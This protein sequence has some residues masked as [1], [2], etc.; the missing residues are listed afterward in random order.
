MI[1]PRA[2]AVLKASGQGWGSMPLF[3]EDRRRAALNN[4]VHARPFASVT[5]PM[6]ASH[7]AVLWGEGGAAADL[8]HLEALCRRHDVPPPLP[9]A[10][11]FAAGF[12]AFALK[13]ERH[14]EFST[15]IFMLEGAAGPNGGNAFDDPAIARVPQ[16]WLA[17]M[18][19]SVLVAAH[20][21]MQ[22]AES[23]MPDADSLARVLVA[24][25]TAGSGISG[26]VAHAWT[27]FQLHADGFG[28]VLVRDCG[29]DGRRMGPRQAGRMMQRL[30]EI[31]TYRM[32]ALLSLP[33]ARDHA[34][35]IDAIGE[36]LA[37]LTQGLS[38]I[39]G[40]DDERRLLDRLVALAAEAERIAAAT[41]Y[42]FGAGRA[43]HQLVLR[44]IE[45]LR[46]QRI[47]G[48]QTIGEFMDRRLAPAMRTCAS[49]GERLETISVR[50][51]RTTALLRARV[52]VALEA[53]NRD[54]LAS[55][56][57]RA[58]LQL[59][60]QQTVEGLSVAAICYYVVGL[61]AYAAKG[62]KTA[63]LPVEPD[64]ASALAVVPVAA[65]VWLALRRLRRRMT[66]D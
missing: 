29:A 17:A 8:A 41:T 43:Y 60:L 28:R 11:H 32:M 18:P 66:R 44:R 35:R 57:R 46:E 56:D 3:T 24:D 53:Q 25:T 42:R 36:E 49:V 51:A 62:L 21:V 33:V 58:R 14:T 59:R 22:S 19:G 48:L 30:L 10:T 12:G 64:L 7:L 40:L 26:G 9:G 45:E 54:L 65:I 15:Y 31:E 1:D 39:A 4:E 20:F 23:P 16:D 38:T 5:A 63:G 52:D 6:R 61:V 34:P 47:E 55:M 2:T 13:W 27:D 50:L 37:R